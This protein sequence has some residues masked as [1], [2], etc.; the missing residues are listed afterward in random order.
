MDMTNLKEQLTDVISGQIPS[1][2][3]LAA[4]LDVQPSLAE[5]LHNIADLIRKERCGDAV[6]LRGIIE[7]SNICNQSCHYCGLRKE[8]GSLTRYRM[9]E[10][11]IMDAAKKIQ[12]AGT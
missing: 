11:E 7:T 2:E 1:R 4:I 6:L 8:N 10:Q 12:N 3:E 5:Y 9:K